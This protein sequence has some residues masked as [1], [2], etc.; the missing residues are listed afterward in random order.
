MLNITCLVIRA[1][2]PDESVAVTSSREHAM[3]Q[4]QPSSPHDDDVLE[5]DYE[6]RWDP[7]GA[8]YDM[9]QRW[10]YLCT[11]AV[12]KITSLPCRYASDVGRD[13]MAVT[14]SSF[15]RWAT[16]FE[17]QELLPFEHLKIL[18]REVRPFG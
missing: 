7:T 16:D 3:T 1:N 15:S 13:T 5:G 8:M 10:A 14:M 4:N 11:H 9:F 12:V 17:V 6:G 18:F 2:G